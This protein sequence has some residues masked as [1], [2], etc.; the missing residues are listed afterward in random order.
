MQ[1]HA[2][3]KSCGDDVVRMKETK[4]TKLKQMQSYF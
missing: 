3:G 4:Q 1:T 2:Y